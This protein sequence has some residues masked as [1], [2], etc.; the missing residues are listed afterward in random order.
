MTDRCLNAVGKALRMIVWVQ[1]FF[2]GA[3]QE[4]G[5]VRLGGGRQG[6]P[7]QPLVAVGALLGSP[8]SNV[9]C[10]AEVLRTRTP[11]LTLSPASEGQQTSD[12]MCSDPMRRVLRGTEYALRTRALM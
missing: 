11:H 9:L 7:R 12:G 1:P 6:L 10:T 8:T 3:G 4:Q 5:L 2:R